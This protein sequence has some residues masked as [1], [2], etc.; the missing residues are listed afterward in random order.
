M[1]KKKGKEEEEW[2]VGGLGWTRMQGRSRARLP[3]RA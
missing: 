1:K 3:A 2:A